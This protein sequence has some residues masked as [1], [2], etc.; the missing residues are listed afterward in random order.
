MD[1]I[2]LKRRDN[3]AYEPLIPRAE[4]ADTSL[5]LPTEESRIRYFCLN[6]PGYVIHSPEA[7]DQKFLTEHFNVGT[8]KFNTEWPNGLG[9]G[10]DPLL[11]QMEFYCNPSAIIPLASATAWNIVRASVTLY[12]C[13]RYWHLY[14]LENSIGEQSDDAGNIMYPH[15]TMPWGP[16]NNLHE[17]RECDLPYQYHHHPYY[18][19]KGEEADGAR[20]G[21]KMIESSNNQR[22]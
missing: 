6:L 13:V 2:H 5:V 18:H 16:R 19:A 14:Q 8:K 22:N 15:L 9:M 12:A 21:Q 20:K 10:I 7:E 3:D 17:Q 1:R 4:G 11:T